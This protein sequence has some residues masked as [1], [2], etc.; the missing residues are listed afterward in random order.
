MDESNNTIFTHAKTEYTAQLIDV[1]TPNFFDGVKQ[2]MTKL[3][4]FITNNPNNTSILILF[5]LFL[6]KVPTWSNEL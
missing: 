2:F 3:K 5:R 1:L 4:Q 6:E